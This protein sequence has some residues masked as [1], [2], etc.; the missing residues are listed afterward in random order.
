MKRQANRSGR[1]GFT[2]VE[3]LVA[4]LVLA[5]GVL[6]ALSIQFS[7]LDGAVA[8]RDLTTASDVAQRI[9]HIMNVEAQVWR[10]GDLGSSFAGSSAYDSSDANWAVNSMLEAAVRGSNAWVSL[11][12]VPVD[13]RLSDDGN[14]RY[15]AYVRGRYLENRRDTGDHRDQSMYRAHIAVV[16]PGSGGSFEDGECPG[17]GDEPISDMEP[18]QS[19]DERGS[20]EREGYRAVHLGTII[21]RRGHLHQGAQS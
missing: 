3:I 9:D 14:Q 7:A 10:Q 19:P 18:K 1:A 20:L 5:V 12:E 21:T 11:F 13:A 6:G 17:S 16:Y 8:S 15:C 4:M 2:L